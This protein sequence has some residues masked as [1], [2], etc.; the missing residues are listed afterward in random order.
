[1]AEEQRVTG[2]EVGRDVVCE[3]RRLRGVGRQQH[4]DVGPLGDLGRSVDLEALLDDFL[5]GLGALFQTHLHL[6]AGVA[7]AQ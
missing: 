7:Q 4:D 5:P 6:G 2:L 3:D 1:M